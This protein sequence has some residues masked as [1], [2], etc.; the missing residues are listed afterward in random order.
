MNIDMINNHGAN[1]VNDMEHIT[2]GNP[3]SAGS[4]KITEKMGFSLDITGKVRE[5][6]AYGKEELKSAEEI[7]QIAGMTDVSLQRDYMAVMSNSMS[8]EDLAQLVKDGVNPTKI[9]AGE[10]VTNLDRIKIRM[11]EAGNTIAG[12]NDDL[13]EEEITAVLGNKI[14]AG[15]VIAKNLTSSDLP[16]T[17]ENVSGIKETVMMALNLGPLSDESKAYM[18]RE[19]ME[20]TVENLYKAEY[21]AAVNTKADSGVH[22]DGAATYAGSAYTESSWDDLKDQ[23]V[24]VIK[25]A[26]IEINEETV[27]DA[28]WIAMH[29]IPLTKDTLEAYGRIKDTVL[30]AAP[31]DLFAAMNVAIEEGRSPKEADLTQTKSLY[32]R[33]V[34]IVDTFLK[35]ED[36]GD[37]TKRRQLEEVRLVMT[38]EANLTLLRKGINIETQPLEKLVDALKEAEREFWAPVLTDGKTA[39]DL[40]GSEEADLDNKIDIYRQTLRVMEEIP[41]I[42][43][44]AI[45]ETVI[46]AD[47]VPAEIPGIIRDD[48]KDDI[49]ADREA[50]A[51]TFD[52]GSIA[53]TGRALAAAYERAGQSYEALMTAPR[54]DMGD[55]IRKAFANVDDILTDLDMDLNEANRKAV[56]TLGYAG[57]SISR[58]TVDT[59][60]SATYSAERVISLMTPAK[61]LSMIREGHNPLGE[62]IFDLEKTLSEETFEETGEKYSRFLLRLEKNGDITEDEKQ[63]FIGIYRLF[64]KIE[65]KDGKVIGNVLSS[66]K[67]LTLENML[68]ASRSNRHM[69]NEYVIDDDFGLL[70]D[71]VEKGDSITAQIE[72][73]FPRL[74][75]P[76]P[77][78]DMITEKQR[79]IRAAGKVTKDAE[80]I[81]TSLS[82]PVTAENILAV[83]ALT[84]GMGPGYKK[85]FS[86][87]RS[88]EDDRKDRDR[89]VLTEDDARA[90][91]EELDDR[92]SAMAAYE[93]FLEKAGSAARQQALSSDK[94]EDVRS[95]SMIY[96]QVGFAASLARRESYEVPVK[97]D[98]GWTSIHLT[99]VH[100]KDGSGKVRTSFE[101]DEYGKVEA[102]FALKSAGIDGFIVSDSRSGVDNLKRIDDKIREGFTR[103]N[104]DTANLSYVFSNN[105][106]GEY[107]PGSDTGTVSNSSLYKIA[108]AFIGAVNKV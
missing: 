12:Y 69:N 55:S 81:L 53:Q 16:V 67:E 9:P 79:E 25:E 82:E 60:R 31:E 61:T 64:D 4:G 37:I 56:R 74:M 106:P 93:R 7:A 92:E 78:K 2:Y 65:K 22:F 35:M 15:A 6:A 3:A 68:E 44:R 90:L 17:D 10:T 33:A 71:L 24:E 41:H 1:P 21:S 73:V 77:D 84:G 88:F 85:L 34:E 46:A 99:I 75:D 102:T 91:S 26:G 27:S 66:G 104:M 20:P 98:E 39:S 103:E 5:N 42:P 30:P 63:A 58:E 100:S 94:Y 51:E 59:V 89:R 52:L 19:E 40:S 108:K 105:A 8:D 97:L 28:K 36:P 43:V 101:S 45:A 13:S 32:V 50:L 47:R 86:G 80:E 14:N 54:A 62:N 38:K 70:E 76:E 11:A 57:M 49:D 23:A 72:R 87:E 83:N 107:L 29:E 96:K 48:L 18:I 95:F